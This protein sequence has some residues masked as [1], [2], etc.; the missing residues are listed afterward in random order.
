MQLVWPRSKC[1]PEVDGTH[2]Q[3]AINMTTLTRVQ[4]AVAVTTLTHVQ[5]ALNFNYT[6]THTYS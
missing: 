1:T 2:R 3:R 4:F 5:C 6:H